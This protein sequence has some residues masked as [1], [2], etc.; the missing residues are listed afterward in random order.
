MPPPHFPVLDLRP[1]TIPYDASELAQDPPATTADLVVMVVENTGGTPL[2]VPVPEQATLNTANQTI[3]IC[4]P[5][6]SSFLIVA[7]AFCTP[8]VSSK[9][10]SIPADNGVLAV[11]SSDEIPLGPNP[12][13]DPSAIQISMAP[14][15]N[16]TTACLAFSFYG[17]GKLDHLCVYNN[18]GPNGYVDDGPSCHHFVADGLRFRLDD[19]DSCGLLPDL[20]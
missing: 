16:T 1:L 14:A 5:H 11:S 17:D 19:T 7:P 9:P 10:I 3:T 18:V 8:K 4:T 12:G 20:Q 13:F 2:L 6:L 15:G